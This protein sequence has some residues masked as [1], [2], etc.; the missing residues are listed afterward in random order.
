MLGGGMPGGGMRPVVAP[1][2]GV[3]PPALGGGLPAPAIGGAMAGPMRAAPMPAAPP[4]GMAM[5]P[6]A[7]NPQESE[8]LRR[9]F[10]DNKP[11]AGLRTRLTP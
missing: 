2:G 11:G 3:A 6:A 5:Q 1:G 7:T 8:E 9:W 4:V 10:E